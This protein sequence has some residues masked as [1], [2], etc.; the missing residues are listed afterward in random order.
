MLTHTNT[1]VLTHTNK[2]TQA[3]TDTYVLTHTYT[4]TRTNTNVLTHTNQLTHTNTYVLTHT[5]TLTRA[6]THTPRQPRAQRLLPSARGP[7]ARAGRTNSDSPGRRRRPHVLPPNASHGRM[8]A[9]GRGAIRVGWARGHGAGEVVSHTSLT[10]Q[11]TWK[12]TQAP[13]VCHPKPL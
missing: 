1:N 7:I 6:N 5:Y 9:R 10:L 11:T 2:P 13:Q 4:L 3:H 8:L 12:H